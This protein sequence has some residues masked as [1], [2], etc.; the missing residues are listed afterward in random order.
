[1][2]GE[3]PLDELYDFADNTLRDRLTVLS[4]VADVELI[5]GAEREVHVSLDRDKLA[6]RGL[7]S[8]D[9]VRVIQNAVR[10]IPSGRIQESGREYSVKFDAEYK[11]VADIGGLEVA[12]EDG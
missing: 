2:T 5:G 10:T 9:V 6:A 11:E 12:N 4:G 8:S 3:V 1:M 7:S